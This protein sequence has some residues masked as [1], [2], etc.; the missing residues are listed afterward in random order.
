MPRII[1]DGYEDLIYPRESAQSAQ[2]RVLTCNE[3]TRM[4]RIGAGEGQ[5]FF[6][7]NE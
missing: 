5:V 2:I 1:T 4:P 7:Q 6:T 3:G